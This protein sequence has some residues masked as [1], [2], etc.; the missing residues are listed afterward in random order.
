M[1]K[2][3][4][5]FTL[6]GLLCLTSCADSESING[7]VAASSGVISLSVNLSA[8]ATS[9][10]AVKTV[11]FLVFDEVGSNPNLEVN[12]LRSVDE[13]AQLYATLQVT[14]RNTNDKLILIIAN[15]PVSL[16]AMLND[17]NGTEAYSTLEGIEVDF[18]DFLNNDMQSFQDDG[19][20][21]MTGAVCTSTVYDTQNDAEGNRLPIALERVAARVDVYL[22]TQ[23][24]EELVL[25]SNSTIQLLNISTKGN[26]VRHT[27]SNASIAEFGSIPTW[28]R[29]ELSS[30]Q[31]SPS[32]P[33]NQI[34]Q[35]VCSFY[36]PE[37]TCNASNYED[38]LRLCVELAFDGEAEPR[39]G[40]FTLESFK[41]DDNVPQEI[42]AINRN[43][44]YSVVLGL[45]DLSSELLAHID[46]W[47][48]DNQDV[49]LDG[50]YKLTVTVD[51]K[52]TDY[53][54][55][56][57][58][59]V[60]A[61]TTYDRNDLGFPKGVYVGDIEYVGNNGTEWLTVNASGNNGDLA[62]TFTFTAESCPVLTSGDAQRVAKV[63]I[64]AGNMTKVI[65]L[66]QTAP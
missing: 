47:E 55:S 5:L 42:S 2:L 24:E 21:P 13:A 61:E 31:C 25:N 22:K 39:I 28:N 7:E 23:S 4:L 43:R 8:N 27:F 30:V 41:S 1:N 49:I 14:K 18:G 33:I 34:E 37:R 10:D 51:T 66:T 11:R 19:V 44:I 15:E 63:S 58:F 48:F 54:G 3:L 16:K 56:T 6:A 20:M 46:S 57:P 62:R 35:M 17:L 9:E 45:K 53:T 60:E 32:M 65:R 64:V 52:T 29:N 59:I 40:E 50:Q 26:L 38:K 36:I 12:E